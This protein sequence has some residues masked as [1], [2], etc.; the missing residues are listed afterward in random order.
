MTVA[1]VFDALVSKRVY[2]EAMDIEEAFREMDMN[3]GLQFDPR[4]IEAFDN[5]KPQLR[6]LS[7][8]YSE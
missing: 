6:E 2:K 5:I 8:K 1:D 7:E 4:I 3:S